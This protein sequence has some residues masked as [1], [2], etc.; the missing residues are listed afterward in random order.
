MN[1][2]E[3]FDQ[4][5]RKLKKNFNEQIKAIKTKHN[6][7]YVSEN[8]MPGDSPEENAAR[9]EAVESRDKYIDD[10]ENLKKQ[11]YNSFNELEQ[12]VEEIKKKE[13]KKADNIY[14]NEEEENLFF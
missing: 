12:K 5:E 10:Y 2:V 14:R 1:P 11:L 8:Y 7:R 3:E 6:V 4:Q 13:E 9:I